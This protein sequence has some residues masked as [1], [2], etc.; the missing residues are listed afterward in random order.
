MEKL[1][2]DYEINGQLGAGG[3]GTVYSG[4]RRRDNLPVSLQNT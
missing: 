3:F 4:V 2:T 1:E